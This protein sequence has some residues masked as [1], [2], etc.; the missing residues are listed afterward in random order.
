M[1]PHPHIQ[2]QL[3]RDRQAALLDEARR[4]RLVRRASPAASPVDDERVVLRLDRVGDEARLRDLA[5][6]SERPLADGRFVVSEV[7]GVVVAALP[8]AGGAPIADPTVRALHLVPLLE[9]RAAQIRG[10]RTRPRR[11]L[12]SLL[13]GRA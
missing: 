13:L 9:L 2:L 3:A 1:N 10:F 5:A 12:R 6:M 11:P 4:E 7:D 8:L